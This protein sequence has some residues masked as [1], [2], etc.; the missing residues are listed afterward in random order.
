[1]GNGANALT[2]GVIAEQMDRELLLGFLQPA[3]GQGRHQA[4]AAWQQGA[5]HIQDQG[6]DTPRLEC[7]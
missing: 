2:G 7:F 6:L 3:Q 5:I 1:L 4:L